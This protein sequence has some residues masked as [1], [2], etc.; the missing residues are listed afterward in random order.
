M[1]NKKWMAVWLFLGA[2]ASCNQVDDEVKPQAVVTTPQFQVSPRE[3]ANAVRSML[4]EVT[5]K[6]TRAGQAQVETRE[7]GE[8]IDLAKWKTTRGISNLDAD[9]AQKFY[10]VN[11]KDN[12]GYAFVS[13]DKRT[14]PVYALLD[15]GTF[16]AS[17]LENE[18]LQWRMKLMLNSFNAEVA[19]FN[20]LCDKIA[21]EKISDK[22]TRGNKDDATANTEKVTPEM[23]SRAGWDLT[24]V[25]PPKMT[26]TWEQK[27]K[28]NCVLNLNG[29]KK[30]KLKKISQIPSS[31]PEVS[32]GCTSVAFGQV[33]YAL[34]EYPGFRD[35]RYT[36][37]E[38]VE[39]GNMSPYSSLEPENQ[40]FLGWITANCD[41]TH[42]KNGETMI[43]N[44]KATEF[45]RKK[46]GSYI[47]S[48]Y[49]NC[50]APEGDFD[51]Y[52]WSEDERVAKEFFAHPKTC[53]MIMTAAA[54]NSIDLVNQFNFHYH[55]YVV[56]GMTEHKK[57]QKY[58]FLFVKWRKTTTR[59]TYHVNAGWGG[60]CNGYYLFVD[61]SDGFKYNGSNNR[62]DYRSK[63]AYLILRPKQDQP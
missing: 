27:I 53:Y 60:K 47:E 7:V 36:N 17:S 49:D 1:S 4:S 42:W 31:N 8:V 33:M 30:E 63:A 34:R 12:Q 26:T 56:D 61:S 13:K 48:R 25:A 32:F 43:F 37:G 45:L 10:V 35:L 11:L 29:L 5:A 19:D 59:H 44:I 54:S 23:L 3:A 39:W 40:R 21:K 38:K 41:P 24:A 57:T 6:S 16:D 52:G 50:I 58:Y 18:E 46:L 9:I 14:F 20:D 51:G 2:L 28:N 15:K 22:A 55:T 62:M